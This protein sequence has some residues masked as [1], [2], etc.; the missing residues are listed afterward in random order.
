MSRK[1][2]PQQKRRIRD[3]HRKAAELDLKHQTEIKFAR[4]EGQA[5]AYHEG[6]QIGAKIIRDAVLDHSGR[7]FKELK[8][9]AAIAVRDVHARLPQAV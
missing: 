4:K 7:L 9:E 6:R 1:L 5:D 3:A 8:D 2:T